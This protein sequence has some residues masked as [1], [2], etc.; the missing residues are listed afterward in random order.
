LV[1][2]DDLTACAA[3]RALTKSGRVVPRDCSVVGFDDIPNS[4]FY[5]PPLTTIQQQLE[6][7]G[8][9]GAEI[10]EELIRATVENRTAVPRHRKVAPRL[11]VRESTCPA[12]RS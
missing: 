5:N 12:P 10:L 8:T 3:I 6:M 1:A 9:L 7:Q 2:F 4:A 11:I